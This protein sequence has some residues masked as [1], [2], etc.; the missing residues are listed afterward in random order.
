MAPHDEHSEVITV[1]EFFEE[2][3][4]IVFFGTFFL[5]QMFLPLL[6]MEN[7]TWM[8]FGL[9]GTILTALALLILPMFCCKGNKQR[10]G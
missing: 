10:H 3:G 9:A 6:F 8:Y 2:Y 7:R 1:T 4:M 5:M